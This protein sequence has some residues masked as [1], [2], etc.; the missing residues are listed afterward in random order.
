MIDKIKLIL[1]I[2]CVVAGVWAYYYFSE[3]AQVLRVLMVLAGLLGG[4][5]IAWLAQPGKEF[6]AFS[7]ESVQEAKRVTWPT[8]KETLQTTLV[9]FV[10]VIVMAI[11][12]ALIDGALA[13]IIK[14]IM[15]Q[16]QS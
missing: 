9:V 15:G 16:S 10:F 2:G 1:A 4:A 13:W 14:L 5:A 6:F 7:Q 3:M 12:L 11:F 8:R